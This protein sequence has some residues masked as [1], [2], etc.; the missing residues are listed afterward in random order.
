MNT[1]TR[2]SWD[3]TERRRSQLNESKVSLMIEE[4]VAEELGKTEIRIMA[5]FDVKAAQFHTALKALTDDAF[6]KGDPRSHRDYHETVMTAADR[7]QRIRSS[8]IENTLKGVA[9]CMLGFVA[10]SIWEHV[11]VLVAK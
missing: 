3:G 8:L 4:S 10:M 7:W 6:P 11:K 2:P 1:P 9:W 5:H